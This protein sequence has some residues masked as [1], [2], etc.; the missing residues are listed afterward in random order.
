MRAKASVLTKRQP[1][2]KV[3]QSLHQVT[4]KDSKDL[5][6]DKAESE[7]T[8][9]ADLG[10]E[11][12]YL[13]RLRPRGGEREV[14]HEAAPMSVYE[15]SERAELESGEDG[16]VESDLERVRET[17]KAGVSHYEK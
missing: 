14:A 6:S 1:R 2:K 13:K 10:D 11:E 15:G 3:H 12:K 9:E 17:E 16:H 7:H 8:R 4:Q 5:E